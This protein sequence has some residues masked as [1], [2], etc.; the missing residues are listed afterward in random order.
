MAMYNMHMHLKP[1]QIEALCDREKLKPQQRRDF[2]FTFRRRLISFLEFIAEAND[3]IEC[4]PR[5]QLKKNKKIKKALSTPVLDKSIETAVDESML[6]VENLLDLLDYAPIQGSP[7][8]AHIILWDDEKNPVSVRNAT[9]QDLNRN[10]AVHAF[11]SRL[12]KF[13]LTD[14][15]LLLKHKQYRE[16]QKW[17]QAEIAKKIK[18]EEPPA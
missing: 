13:Y 17:E 8:K 9:N 1:D 12:S 18:K 4:L 15:D 11:V 2:D 16:K 7:E 10:L 5:D 3:I 6:L 14:S